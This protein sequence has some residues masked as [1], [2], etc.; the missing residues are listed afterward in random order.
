MTWKKNRERYLNCN[1][2]G[3]NVEYR[4]TER[5]LIKALLR[6]TNQVRNQVK[7]K[8]KEIPGNSYTMSE[9][10]LLLYCI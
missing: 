9:E 1:A 2:L 6:V 4:G 10:R 7:K 5:E 8:T 3:G